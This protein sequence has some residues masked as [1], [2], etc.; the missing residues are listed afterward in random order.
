MNATKI[1]AFLVFPLFIGGFLVGE[2]IIKT[3]LNEQWYPMITVFKYLCLT[4]I[5]MAINA[6]NN[7]AHAA[8]DRPHWGMFY[9]IAGVLLMPVSFYLAVP[10]GLNAIIFPWMSTFVLLCGSWILITLKKI[11]IPITT[12]IRN[13][14]T[15]ITA[16]AIMMIMVS[17][18]R[19]SLSSYNIIMNNNLIKFILSAG[20]G[21]LFYLGCIW[22]IDRNLILNVKLL[23]RK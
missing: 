7:F 5:L 20:I 22:F 15:P 12:Y 14:M 2:D 1:T 4:Q 13:L 3:I 16:S 17:A 8:Q 19:Y 21:G 23:R 10:Y 6:I 9:H 18:F 11:G